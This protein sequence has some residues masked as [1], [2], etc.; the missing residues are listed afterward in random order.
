MV[1]AG[2]VW[3]AEQTAPSRV[4]VSDGDPCFINGITFPF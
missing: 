1:V 2:L 4:T 3:Q